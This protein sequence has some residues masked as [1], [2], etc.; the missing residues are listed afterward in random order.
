MIE[1]H[2]VNW[3]FLSSCVLKAEVLLHSYACSFIFKMVVQLQV[4]SKNIVFLE[5]ITFSAM[6]WMDYSFMVRTKTSS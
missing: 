3:K 6:V 5:L 4:N 1:V 2:L